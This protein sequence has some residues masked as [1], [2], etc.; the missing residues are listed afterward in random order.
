MHVRVCV[1]AHACACIRTRV[2]VYALAC[3]HASTIPT[4][5]TD[6]SDVS[7]Q[8]QTITRCVPITR[9]HRTYSVILKTGELRIL[10]DHNTI[11]SSTKR[12]K[13]LF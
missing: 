9:N 11:H 7:T 1:R 4:L 5:P 6:V 10:Y 2:H 13:W 8:R 3:A 12:Y